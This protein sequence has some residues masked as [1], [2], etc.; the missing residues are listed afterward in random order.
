MKGSQ[1]RNL[2]SYLCIKILNQRHKNK[3]K[4]F[5]YINGLHFEALLPP[6]LE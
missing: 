3:E 5:A 1:K 6:I 2:H 4:H